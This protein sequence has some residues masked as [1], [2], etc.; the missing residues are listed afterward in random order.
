MMHNFFECKIKYE[1][2]M[3]DGTNKNVSEL[4]LLDALSFT[5]AEKKRLTILH[6]GLK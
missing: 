1:K 5:E 3:E 2:V 4:Y 6:G